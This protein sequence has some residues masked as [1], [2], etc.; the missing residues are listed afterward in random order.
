MP[1]PI[2]LGYH[3]S[4]QVVWD[5][6][7][8][9]NIGDVQL[10]EYTPADPFGPLRRGEQDAIIVRFGID[11]P[12]LVTG[13]VL[14]TDQ[15]AAVLARTHPLATRE[16][17]SIEE[18]AGVESF[19][20]PGGMPGY[21]WD[22][23]VP[24]RTPAGAPIHRVHPWSTVPEL[25]SLVVSGNA[26][27]LSLVSIAEVAPPSVAVIPVDDL[28]PAPVLLGWRRDHVPERARELIGSLG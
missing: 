6:L 19:Q 10:V 20:A 1:E 15:R 4:S 21:V 5:I 22:Q 27:H 25:I 24:P 28:E 8:E 23:V 9:A 17:I 3:G 14:G 26:V 13:R 7:R 11:E 18:L 16:S 12:D 2:R